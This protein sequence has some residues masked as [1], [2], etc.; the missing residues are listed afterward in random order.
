LDREFHLLM[1]HNW[2]SFQKDE[3][4]LFCWSIQKLGSV[5]VTVFVSISVSRPWRLGCC[6]RTIGGQLVNFPLPGAPERGSPKLWSLCFW[7][8]NIRSIPCHPTWQEEY[9]GPLS[10]LSFLTA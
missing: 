8:M 1:K 4:S 7:T 3:Q 10:I 2:A 5:W 6:S 9:R